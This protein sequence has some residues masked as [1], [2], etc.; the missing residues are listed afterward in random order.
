MQVDQLLDAAHV[1]AADGRDDHD[2]GAAVVANLDGADSR[3]EAPVGVAHH[4]EGDVGGEVPLV[5]A[6][7][8]LVPLGDDCLEGG[9]VSCLGGLLHRLDHGPNLLLG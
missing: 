4:V 8:V 7:W 9:D 2:L 5:V 1:P 3:E 6:A